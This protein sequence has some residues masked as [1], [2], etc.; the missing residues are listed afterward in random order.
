L[1]NGDLSHRHTRQRKD[2]RRRED[3]LHMKPDLAGRCAPGRA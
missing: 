2:E 1:Q 3:Y